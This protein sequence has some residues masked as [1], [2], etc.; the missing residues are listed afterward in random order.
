MCYIFKFEKP[1][2]KP[3]S[4]PQPTSTPQN[5]NRGRKPLFT[6]NE[7]QAFPLCDL[8]TRRIYNRTNRR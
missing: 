6:F 8:Q 7:M 3:S 4:N 1:P 2:E 5:Q